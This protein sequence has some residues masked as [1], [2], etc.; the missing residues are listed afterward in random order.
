MQKTSKQAEQ[1]PLV[2]K[3]WVYDKDGK[4]IAEL[5]KASFLEFYFTKNTT[6]SRQKAC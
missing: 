6:D 4:Q 3:S 5:I 1:K 2:L